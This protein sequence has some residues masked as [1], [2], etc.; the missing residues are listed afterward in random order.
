MTFSNRQ[1]SY[2]SSSSH[3]DN[4]PSKPTDTN[5]SSTYTKLITTSKPTFFDIIYESFAF[6]EYFTRVKDEELL[7]YEAIFKSD[8]KINDNIISGQSVEEAKTKLST[9]EE[10]QKYLSNLIKGDTGVDSTI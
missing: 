1:D 9:K 6:S 2:Y 4:Y 10:F 7:E 5:D 8:I 3:S